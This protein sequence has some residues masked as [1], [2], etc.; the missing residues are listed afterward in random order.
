[1]KIL[2][3]VDDTKSTNDALL[4]ISKQIRP[5][6]AEVRLVHVVQPISESTPPQMSPDFTP[7]LEV[8]GKLAK[9]LLAQAEKTFRAAGFKTDTVLRKGDVRDSIV[10]SAKE[11]H[12][13]LV[14][15]GSHNHGGIHRFLLGSVAESVARH[16]PCSVEIVR[17]PNP[18]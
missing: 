4:S 2:V 8:E 14:V 5:E 9:D 10:E 3:A 11:W 16:A 18:N 17:N 6:N 1:M 7:E 15:L 12:A 13:D